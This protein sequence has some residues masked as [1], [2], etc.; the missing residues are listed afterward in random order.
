MRLV[1]RK[2]KHMII[3][4]G[5]SAPSTSREKRKV[6]EVSKMVSDLLNHAYVMKLRGTSRLVNTVMCWEVK[7][8]NST[9]KGHG[10]SLVELLPDIPLCVCCIIKL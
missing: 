1:T 6:T 5:L 2:T 9:S 10:H 3:G 8:P 4:L 7:H